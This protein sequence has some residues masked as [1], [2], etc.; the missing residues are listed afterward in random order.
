MVKKFNLTK[1]ELIRTIIALAVLYVVICAVCYFLYVMEKEHTVWEI[2]RFFGLNLLLI[3]VLGVYVY[4]VNIDA[5]KETRQLYALSVIMVLGLAIYIVIQKFVSPYLVPYAFIA[6]TNGLVISKRSG[7]MSAFVVIMSMFFAQ[8]M[9][10]DS[11]TLDLF[12]P[13]FVGLCLSIIS[14]FMLS[15]QR[16]RVKYFAVAIILSL[17]TFACNILF[18]LAG[19]NP[20]DILM[21]SIYSL[22]SGFLSVALFWFAVPILDSIFNFVTDFRLAEL[23]ATSAPLMKRMY[24]EAPGTFNHCLTVAN[25]TEA[26]ANAISENPYLAR[27]AAY[28]HDIGKIKNPIYFK[29]NQMDGHNPHDEI[30]PELSTALIK[31]HV[32]NG[33]LMAKEYHLPEKVSMYIQEHHGTMPI[34]F[35]YSKAQKYT[36]GILEDTGFRYDGPT[37]SNKISAI[38][39]ICDASEAALRALPVDNRMKAETIVSNL[40]NDRLKYHQFDNCDIT[41]RELNIIKETIVTVY[42]GINHKRIAYPDQQKTDEV[43]A[44]PR[45]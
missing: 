34:Q 37:P 4:C 40:I 9:S 17:S 3:V 31:K 30:T 36:D 24:E 39:M 14:A 44:E 45:S 15:R 41:M 16:K 26:C 13:F 23:T 19:A 25:Y 32:S 29:E 12:M 10:V 42:I 35:F 11:V 8:S 7:F 5:L 43:A 28:Y 6:L 22:L 38:L 1:K 33:M 21:L 20:V 27:A 2:V 18:A